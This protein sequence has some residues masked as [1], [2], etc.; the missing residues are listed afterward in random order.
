MEN[1][2]CDL[3]NK[4]KNIVGKVIKLNHSPLVSDDDITNLFL[5]LLRLVKRN[6]EYLCEK[7]Y[8]RII[9]SLKKEINLLRLQNR[10]FEGDKAE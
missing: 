2:N 7:K 4:E 1:N 3:E 8:G 10:L 5:G 6:A 9:A